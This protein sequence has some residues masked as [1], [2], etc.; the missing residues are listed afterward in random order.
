MPN[1]IARFASTRWLW[2][3]LGV[4][5]SAVG[6]EPLDAPTPITP[7]PEDGRVWVERNRSAEA[8]TPDSPAMT[9]YRNAR[10]GGGEAFDCDLAVQV[11]R[12]S[13]SRTALAAALNN[14]ALMLAREGRLEPA[15]ED[16]NAAVVQ[17]P[18]DP[19]LHGNLGNLLLRL[20]RPADALRAHDR[21]VALAPDAAAGYYNRAFS[22]LALSELDR[23]G[24]DVAAA[25]SLIGR[26]NPVAAPEMP[27]PGG[28]R[29]R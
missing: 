28:G 11:A 17:A 2:V 15:L 4:M 16:L 5:G 24:Q 13:G 27:A 7:P 20:G 9:C 10:Q 22:Y 29:S 6:Q 19:A 23:A 14:R 8:S 21:A 26:Q 18:D 3:S 1:R 25:R 12:D